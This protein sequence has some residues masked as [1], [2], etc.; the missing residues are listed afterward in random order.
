V[1]FSFGAR[2]FRRRRETLDE[3][4]LIAVEILPPPKTG[5]STSWADFLTRT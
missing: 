3:E 4:L 1:L 2:I 5:A